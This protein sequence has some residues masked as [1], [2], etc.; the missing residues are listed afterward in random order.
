MITSY[1]AIII[2]EWAS[3]LAA[4][5]VATSRSSR[6]VHGAS[7]LSVWIGYPCKLKAGNYRQSF[8]DKHREDHEKIEAEARDQRD[9]EAQRLAEAALAKKT[10]KNWLGHMN[11]RVN[12]Y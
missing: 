2:V 6:V 4:H 8:L 10:S 11:R 9:L 12:K 1:S 7:C 5:L 3:S